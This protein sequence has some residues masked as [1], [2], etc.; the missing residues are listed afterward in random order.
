MQIEKPF[1]WKKRKPPE[2]GRL[3]LKTGGKD[4]CKDACVPGSPG[5]HAGDPIATRRIE[6][7]QSLF[8]ILFRQLSMVVRSEAERPE[9]SFSHRVSMH[10]MLSS[11][12]V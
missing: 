12:R 3:L 6:V 7:A 11:S 1:F 9:M 10:R 4:T 2:E 8:V 5:F